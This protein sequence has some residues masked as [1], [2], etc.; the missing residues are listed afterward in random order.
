MTDAFIT[1]DVEQD[2]PP[3]LAT[4]R[5]VEQG[6]DK[7][8]TILA[9]HD[10]KATFFVTGAVARQFPAAIRALA[11]AG[12][13]IGC[14]GDTHISL[15]RIG[16]PQARAEIERSTGSLRELAAVT[17]FRAP[18]LQLPDDRL[19][20]LTEF[21]YRVDSSVAR[22]KPWRRP[23]TAAGLLRLPVSLTSSVLRLPARL[24]DRFIAT[25]RDPVVLFVHP[26][27]LVDLTREPIRWD[28]RAGTGA[29]A[30]TGLDQ[31]IGGLRSRG[32]RF[33]LVREAGLRPAGDRGG[34]AG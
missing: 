11:D 19:G 14:H 32:A 7:I 30:A 6:L 18:Y 15:A 2:C 13:E 22:Y 34:T 4:Y 33:R 9:D 1:V 12:H 17:S 31:A 24:R 21:G 3:Y 27:E 26:W 23:G 20:L 5:G 29:P 28:C 8:V 10:V 25:S 16:R